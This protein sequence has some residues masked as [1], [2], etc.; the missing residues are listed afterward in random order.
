MTGQRQRF[1]PP[2]VRAF[3]PL[4]DFL[5][6]ETAGGILLAVGAALAL[7]WAN[8]P[9]SSSYEE[10]WTT[11]MSVTIGNHALQLTLREWIN[12]GLITIFFV[13]VGL[14]IKRELVSGQLA[15]RRAAL[16]PVVAAIGGMIAPALIYLAIAGKTE[17]RGWGIVVATDIPLALGVLAIA[18]GRVPPSLRAF[19]LALAIVDDIGA[20][21]IIA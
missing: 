8:S 13:V 16:L 21:L 15:N 3:S 7:V 9:W 11:S 18:G 10:L 12:E 20:L 5:H 17:P 2:T 19:I 14:E 4:R 1:A 6:T